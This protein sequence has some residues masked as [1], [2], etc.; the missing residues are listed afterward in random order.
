MAAPLAS[1]DASAAAEQGLLRSLPERRQREGMHAVSVRPKKPSSP[2][3]P[4][5][6]ARPWPWPIG[7]SRGADVVVNY[8][9]SEAP[10]KDLVKQIHPGPHG[11][12]KAVAVKGDVAQEAD[13]R[14]A[15]V[16]AAMNDLG[17]LDIRRQQRRASPAPA[18]L[19]KMTGEQWDQVLGIHLKA[20]WMMSKAAQPIFK[21]PLQGPRTWDHQRDQRGRRGGHR[22]PGQLLGGQGRG[23]QPH[24]VHCPGNGQ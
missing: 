2:G 14:K 9:S 8:S 20:V 22:G 6:S 15:L 11:A 3:L 7:R 18:M 23:D 24:Q 12:Q 10:A 17:G 4:G 13:C 16:D 19:H 21:G 1:N 5:A